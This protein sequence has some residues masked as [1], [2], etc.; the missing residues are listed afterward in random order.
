MIGYRESSD[1]AEAGHDDMTALLTN[2]LPTKSL[3]G[4]DNVSGW[5]NGNRRHYTTT[6]ICRVVTVSGI[7]ISARTSK[8]CLIAS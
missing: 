8:H 3:K 5:E 1:V 7:P 6:S 2:N 4:P